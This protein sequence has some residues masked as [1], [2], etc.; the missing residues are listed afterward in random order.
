[1]KTRFLHLSFGSLNINF[2]LPFKTGMMKI[3]GV[4]GQRE[5]SGAAR[6]WVTQGC[7]GRYI[8]GNTGLL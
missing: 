1:M 5:L 3:S 7:S 4:Y 6:K 8:T 2:H